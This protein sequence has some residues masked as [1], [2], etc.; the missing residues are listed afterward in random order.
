MVV[1]MFEVPAASNGSSARDAGA[2]PR[3]PVVMVAGA[4]GGI[5]KRVVSTDAS[6]LMLSRPPCPL[7]GRAR[8]LLAIAGQ[9]V[10]PL[11]C[12]YAVICTGGN[13]AAARQAGEGA[14]A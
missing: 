13:A 4:T 3:R 7:L 2:G 14:G 5:G 11:A 8:G 6:P 10:L 1:K 12:G 9:A